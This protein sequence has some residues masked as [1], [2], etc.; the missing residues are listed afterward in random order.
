MPAQVRLK[1]LVEYVGEVLG[2]TAAAATLEPAASAAAQEAAAQLH[3]AARVSAAAAAEDGGGSPL[4]AAA[5]RAMLQPQLSQLCTSVTARVR[6]APSSQCHPH[7]EMLLG[8]VT[9]LRKEVLLEVPAGHAM[10]KRSLCLIRRSRTRTE[11]QCGGRRA[12]QCA[13][14]RHSCTRPGPTL[15]SARLPPLRQTTPLLHARAACFPRRGCCTWHVQTVPPCLTAHRKLCN[16]MS[17]LQ[18]CW[19]TLASA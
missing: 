16:R 2:H 3:D 4:A 11:K 19:C 9:G 13:R 7:W 15:S 10:M 17:R 18:D 1:D 5:L 6:A 12:V 8:H 14:W